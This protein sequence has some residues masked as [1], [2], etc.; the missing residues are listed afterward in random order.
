MVEKIPAFLTFEEV[1]KILRIKVQT[2]RRY[3]RRGLLPRPRAI[4]GP[5]VRF[6][7]EEVDAA[8]RSI[9]TDGPRRKVA[10]AHAMPTNATPT[11]VAMPT[12]IPTT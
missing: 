5:L 2:A 9:R 12:A 3:V 4:S 6:V 8:I 11:T 7:G 10:F 1:A